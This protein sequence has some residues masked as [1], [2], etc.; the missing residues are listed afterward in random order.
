MDTVRYTAQEMKYPFLFS[1]RY[2]LVWA[3]GEFSTFPLG[4][5]LKEGPLSASASSAA[6]AGGW[7]ADNFVF[8]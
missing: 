5:A 1:P 2:Y 8:P 3:Q 4:F 7:S 6:A